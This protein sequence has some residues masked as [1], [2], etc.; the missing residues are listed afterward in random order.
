[1]TRMEKRTPSVEPA[2][3]RGDGLHPVQ[4]LA[5]VRYHEIGTDGAA[6]SEILAQTKGALITGKK[7]GLPAHSRGRQDVI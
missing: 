6:S 1:M 3:G 2:P 4:E 7:D 5:Q